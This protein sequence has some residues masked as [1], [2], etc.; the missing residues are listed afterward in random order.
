MGKLNAIVADEAVTR[1]FSSYLSRR[2]QCVSVN[3]SVSSSESVTCG[4][5]QGSILGAL[6]FTIYANDMVRSVNCDLYLY[7]DDSAL[8]VSGKKVSQ[9]EAAFEWKYDIS[10][11]VVGKE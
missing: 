10:Q 4:K 3:G 2:K 8:L 7:A 6:L 11:A 1:W 5:P 9:I